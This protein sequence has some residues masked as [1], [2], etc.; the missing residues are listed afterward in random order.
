MPNFQNGY[1]IKYHF[2]KYGLNQAHY[3]EFRKKIK[4]T[5]RGSDERKKV[6]NDLLKK[7]INHQSEKLLAFADN[8]A[9]SQSR[10]LAYYSDQGTFEVLDSNTDLA[11][12]FGG[13]AIGE[14]SQQA[15]SDYPAIEP[16]QHRSF[17]RNL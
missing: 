11:E 6:I 5:K 13:L 16:E 4:D 3:D 12:R 8:Y 14:K 15:T 2:E 1:N 10:F 7:L 9:K 17:K